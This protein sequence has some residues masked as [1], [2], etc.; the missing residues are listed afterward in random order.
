MAAPS[1]TLYHRWMSG[2]APALR[3]LA[4][5][6]AILVVV[7][8]ALWPFV[9]WPVAVLAGWNA[10]AVMFLVAVLPV[11]A[12]ADGPRTER[13]APREDEGHRSA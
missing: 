8:L 2:Q 6:A 3:R 1:P 9:T 11:I 10:G 7:T 5:D 12:R 4:I 13:L